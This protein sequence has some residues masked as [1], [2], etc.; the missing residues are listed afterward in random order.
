MTAHKN[1][2]EN[3]LRTLQVKDASIY[4][5]LSISQRCE[6]P[7]FS[8]TANKREIGSSRALDPL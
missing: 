2:E 4:T 3:S 8:D 1:H 6:I 7:N 5:Y